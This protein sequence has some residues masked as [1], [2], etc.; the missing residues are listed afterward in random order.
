M[1]RDE[2]VECARQVRPDVAVIDLS[3]P[4][5]SGVEVTVALKDALPATRIVMLSDMDNTSTCE[6]RCERVPAGMS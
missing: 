1:T 6:R 4:A 5:M 2:A 3:M